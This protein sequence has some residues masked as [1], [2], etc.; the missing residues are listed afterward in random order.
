M[1]RATEIGSRLL[2]QPRKIIEGVPETLHHLAPRHH[3]IM[4]TKGHPVEQSLKIRTSGLAIFFRHIEI[5][6]AKNAST[7]SSLADRLA[8]TVRE[9]G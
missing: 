3:L 9:P 6:R 5:T 8:W 1:A 2:H 4:F 7:Y